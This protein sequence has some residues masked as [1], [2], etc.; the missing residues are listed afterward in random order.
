MGKALSSQS[1]C[2]FNSG[3]LTEQQVS[4]VS[5]EMLAPISDHEVFHL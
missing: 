4:L 1:V 5:R 3:W 2:P